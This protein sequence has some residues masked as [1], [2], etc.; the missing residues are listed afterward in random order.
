MYVETCKDEVKSLKFSLIHPWYLCFSHTNTQKWCV[1]LFE[2]AQIG[3]DMLTEHHSRNGISVKD[4]E[5]LEMLPLISLYE[6]CM[7]DNLYCVSSAYICLFVSV[8][9]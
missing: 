6:T 8:L 4:D 3:S 5:L 1:V 9:S 7:R 2:T